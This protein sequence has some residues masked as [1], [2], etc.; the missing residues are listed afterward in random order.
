L[1]QFA[2]VF[3]ALIHDVGHEGVPNFVLGK[4]HPLLAEKYSNKSIAEQR[5][6]DIAWELLLLPQFSHLR[7]SIYQSKSDYTRFRYLC[8]NGVIATD[9]FDK[10]LKELRNSRWETAFHGEKQDSTEAKATM[11]RKATIVIEHIIQASDVAHTMQHFFVYCKWNE[12]LFKEMYFGFL[13]GRLDKDPSAGWY[14]GELWFFD[15]YVI[16]LAKKLKDCNVFGVSSDEYYNYA[17]QNRKEW[18]RKGKTL[19]EIM[20]NKAEKEATELGFMGNRDDDASNNDSVELSL[21][22]TSIDT[23]VGIS[24]N[25]DLIQEVPREVQSSIEA[26]I[27][28]EIRMALE[29]SELP[30]P[31]DISLCRSVRSIK[32]PPGKLGVVV[33]ASEDGTVVQDVSFTSPLKG[34]LYPGDR[35]IE[36][37]GVETNGLSKENLVVLMAAETDKMR[38]FK[39]ESP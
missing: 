27:A 25:S 39:V 15:N 21:G 13:K 17:L 32:V 11:D 29:D 8:V 5:S 4:M 6:V 22:G 31:Q 38:E 19:C 37:N 24:M 30:L 16:P 28:D 9:I 12:R 2:V 20:K 36:I 3:S 7:A 34:R 1:T 26:R 14:S 10:D 35:I 18:E 33:D 23:S